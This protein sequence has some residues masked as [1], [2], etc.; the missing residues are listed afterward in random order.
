ML[1]RKHKVRICGSS[2]AT[3][4]QRGSAQK[5]KEVGGFEPWT[6]RGFLWSHLRALIYGPP[7]N[8]V[9]DIVPQY[10]DNDVELILSGN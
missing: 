3:R 10:W 4:V 7:C 2:G 6:F 9:P 8:I 1:T 5:K